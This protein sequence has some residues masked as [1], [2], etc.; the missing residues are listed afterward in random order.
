M[1]PALPSIPTSPSLPAPKPLPALHIDGERLLDPAGRAVELKGCN[2]GNWLLIEPWM[3][4]VAGKPG[5]PPDAYTLTESLKSRFGA[6]E[7]ERLMDLYRENWMRERDWRLIPTFGFNLVRLPIDYRLLEDDAR[8]KALRPDAWQWLDRAVDAAE[9]HGLYTILDLH[10]AQG[11][12]TPNDH[13][14]RAGQN[15]LWGSEENQSRVAW[16]WTKIARRY[17]DRSAV[18]A[19]DTLNEPYGGTK[20]EIKRVFERSL[21]AIRSVDP[22]KLVFAHG[23]Y[24]GFDFFG[25][26]KANG[27]TNVG[28]QMHY[29]PGLFG[30]EPTLKTQARHLRSLAGVARRVDELNVPFLVGEMNPVLASNGGAAMTRLAFDTHA[31]YGWMT[32]LWSYKVLSEAGNPQRDFWGMA[33]NAEPLPN[34]SLL[35]ASKPEIEAWFS[36]LGT[37]RLSVYEDL[38]RAMTARNPVRPDL[39]NLLEPRLDAPQDTLPGWTATDVGGALKGGLKLGPDGAFDLFGGGDDIWSASDSFRFLSRRAD[40]DFDLS[41]VVTGLEET[42]PYAKAGLMVRDRM[43]PNGATALLSVFPGGEVQV[44]IRDADGGTMTSRAGAPAKGFPRTLKII[45]RGG[46]LRFFADGERLAWN[47]GYTLTGRTFVGPVALSH[48]GGELARAGYRDLAFTER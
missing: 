48:S 40:G 3:L 2:L 27:W 9:A 39:P 14:G 10:G 33:S 6:A 12:Q 25:D 21:A 43:D 1:L 15:K 45:R 44:A 13:T 31:K 42:S 47:G 18:V 24:D 32:T 38:R 46:E 28:F 8:P 41:V 37:M 5:S 19:Y 36:G 29:Y 20:P 34:I 22:T 16:L 7:G 23:F 11:G 4:A 30:S 26:P 17:R 35:T